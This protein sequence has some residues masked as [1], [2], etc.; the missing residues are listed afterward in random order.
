MDVIVLLILATLTSLL[1]IDHLRQLRQHARSSEC[2]DRLQ[3][4]GV[5]IHSYH[6]MMNALP[7][8][9]WGSFDNT[10]GDPDL[11]DAGKDGVGGTGGG[12]NGK[13]LSIF[14]AILP[15]LNQQPLWETI[16]DPS[17]ET[18]AGRLGEK[19]TWNA[20]GPG[21]AQRQFKPWTTDLPQLHCP[22]D[23]RK[24]TIVTGRSNYAVCMGDAVDY[25][26]E[27]A[28]RFEPAKKLWGLD[29]VAQKRIEAAARGPFIFRQSTKLTDVKDGLSNTILVAEIITHAGDL[30]TRSKPALGLGD[31]DSGSPPRGGIF[32]S[33]R[34][35]MP[36]LNP[37]RPWFWS[38]N[39]SRYSNSLRTTTADDENR[40]LRWAD[41][42]TVFSGFTT[43]GPPS[44]PLLVEGNLVTGAAIASPSSRHPG[45][46]YVLFCDGATRFTADS[47]DCGNLSSGSV[48]LG[49]RGK[50]AP[51]SKSPYGVWGTLGTRASTD[52][53]MRY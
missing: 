31:Q 21:P 18:L 33:A 25:Q 3:Q 45:G 48:R 29:E 28:I 12:N 34:S 35:A 53:E 46:V 26:T 52:N 44:W 51:G 5:A 10:S 50:L 49:M 2:Q 9:G 23:P 32:D 43:I 15:Q 14:V 20:L 19:S 47:I 38:S 40:G 7:T 27:S 42:H 11:G 24:G 30:D 4:I 36:P 37:E 6:Q 41:A 22:S 16:T 17:S 1:L 8:H 39:A 13:T